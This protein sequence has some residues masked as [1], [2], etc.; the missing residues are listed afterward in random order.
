MAR[1][2]VKGKG[3]PVSFRFHAGIK[4]AALEVAKRK[5]VTLTDMI[6][7]YLRKEIQKAKVEIKEKDD[8]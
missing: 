5:G 3:N 1:A 6:E 4:D 2:V 7:A 8:G